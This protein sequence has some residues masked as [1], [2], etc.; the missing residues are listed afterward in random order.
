MA[1]CFSMIFLNES[2]AIGVAFPQMQKVLNLS[3]N[4]VQWIMNSFLLTA[5]VLLLLGGKLA[6]HYGRKNIFILGLVI[7]AVASVICTIAENGWVMIAGR[8]LQA[9]GAS[10]AYPSGS[11]LL[12]VSVPEHEFNKI[13]GTVMG[14]AYIFVAFGP[15]IGGLFTD[16]LNWRW[17]FGINIIFSAI[18]I[19]LTLYSIPKD[20]VIKKPLRLD[21]KGLIIFIIGL[22]SLV[23][24]LMQGAV[25]GWSNT[26]ILILFAVAVVGLMI[27]VLV[28]IK[29][30]EPLLQISLFHNKQFMAGNVIF[31]C[32]AACFMALV[33][34]AIWLQQTFSFSPIVTGLAMVPATAISIFMLNISGAWGAKVGAR[35]PM[36]LG[37]CLLVVAI[38]WIALTALAQNYFLIFWG[39]LLFGFATPLVIP[40][41]IGTMVSSVE[42]SQRG[43]ASGVWLTLQHVAFSLGFAILSA[44]ITTH[45]NKNLLTLLASTPNYAHINP[46]QVNMLLAGKNTIS[47]LDPEQLVILKQ[48]A[49]LNY[50]HAFS[51][52]MAVLGI[53]AIIALVFTFIFIPKKNRVSKPT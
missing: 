1:A 32:V 33:F 44:T 5:A 47:Q 7:F 29:N 39:F 52:G 19:A 6:D 25:L 36:L 3:N 24:A 40:N 13:F 34:W 26:W 30:A 48:N 16:L 41:A 10:L 42:S 14:I 15:F 31:P 45:D 2:G 21:I 8:I 18:C 4:A 51:Y 43:I 49:I 22:G 35:I 37:A 28:E 46:Q 50:T 23:V 11:A 12:S 9:I 38:Y 53:F 20:P 27:F 17:L